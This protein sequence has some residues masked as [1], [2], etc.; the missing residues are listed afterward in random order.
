MKQIGTDRTALADYWQAIPADELQDRGLV[1]GVLPLMARAGCAALARAQTERLLEERWDSGLARLYAYCAE[2]VD[3]ARACLHNAES[4]LERQPRDAGLLF[5][6]GQLCRRTELW[7][8]A[9]SYLEASLGLKPEV[10]TH[11]AL[12]HLFDT[13][14]RRND[15]QRHYRA[16]A[17][18]VAGGAV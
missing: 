4:W 16:A 8:K 1:E 9:Q 5:A 14:E 6:L 18:R 13:L 15:A 11:L 3:E 12:A 7:G 2:S 10:D 17:E